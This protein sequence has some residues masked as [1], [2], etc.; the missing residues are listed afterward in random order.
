MTNDRNAKTERQIGSARVKGGVATIELAIV[1]NR[2][3]A[4]NRS[5]TV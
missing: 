3:Y 4:D 1:S 2:S 5:V